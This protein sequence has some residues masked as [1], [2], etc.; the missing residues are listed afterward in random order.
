MYLKLIIILL[1]VFAYACTNEDPPL[2]PFSSSDVHILKDG[3]AQHADS[4]DLRKIESDIAS[5]ILPDLEKDGSAIKCKPMHAEQKTREGQPADGWN[6]NRQGRVFE[7]EMKLKPNEGDFSPSVVRA[8]DSFRLYF[9]RRRGQAFTIWTARSED[10]VD[11]EDPE[12]VQGLEGPHYP[13]ALF[14]DGKFRIWFGSGTIDSAESVDGIHFK[15]Q[16]RGVLRPKDIEGDWAKLS[17]TYPHVFR[18]ETGYRMYFTAFD[19]VTLR[20][21]EANSSDGLVWSAEG[22]FKLEGTQN[23]GFDH[24]SVS[25]ASVLLHEGKWWMWYSGYDTSKTKPG[26]WRVGLATST[27]GTNWT[28]EGVSMALSKDGDDAW[29]TRDAALFF[30]KSKTFSMVYV[31]LSKEQHY[32]LLLATSDTCLK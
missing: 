30:D 2:P 16:K 12:E 28:R 31:G 1:A 27:E 10:G 5:D 13:T 11:W 20:I 29:S 24:T 4:R 3:G 9:A 7:K 21:G 23:G 32:R 14:E 25:G 18:T 6:W 8:V 15:N 22:T 19:G 17:L 26:P